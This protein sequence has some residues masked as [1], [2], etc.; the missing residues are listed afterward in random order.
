LRP[1]KDRVV[2]EFAVELDRG[3]A[4]GFRRS[5]RRDHSFG[6]GDLRL[7]G[8]EDPVDGSDLLRMDAH[9]ALE[10]ETECGSSG[11]FEAFL[12]VEIDPNRVEGRLDTGGA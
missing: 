6:R 4:R 11:H 12:V 7:I 2:D 10:A 1:V 5:E 3:A 9:L 8:R